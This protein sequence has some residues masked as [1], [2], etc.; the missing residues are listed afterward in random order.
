MCEVAGPCYE[1]FERLVSTLPC[2]AQAGAWG[3]W[4]S[5]LGWKYSLE[6]PFAGYEPPSIQREPGSTEGHDVESAWLMQQEQRRSAGAAER[7]QQQQSGQS[8]ARSGRWKD[9]RL[10]RLQ[11]KLREGVGARSHTHVRLPHS[12]S[13]RMHFSSDVLLGQ[14]RVLLK[15][16]I[17]LVLLM[18][19]IP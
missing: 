12:D 19:A 5:A 4:L 1:C 10:G 14:A 8:H 7:L 16:C 13:R 3:P 6:S 15:T 17:K 2:L 11:A 9:A 18:L